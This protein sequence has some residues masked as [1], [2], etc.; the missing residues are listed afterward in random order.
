MSGYKWEN[1]RTNQILTAPAIWLKQKLICQ[2][3]W[4]TIFWSVLSP[5]WSDYILTIFWLHSDYILTT[6]WLNSDYIL[7][8]FWSHSDY[9]L[10]TSWLHSDCI[11]TSLWLFP[12]TFWLLAI[13]LALIR[14][15][16]QTVHFA[17]SRPYI[18]GKLWHLNPIS[19]KVGQTCPNSAQTCITLKNQWAEIL[20]IFVNS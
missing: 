11:L 3:S 18:F 5:F 17:S 2:L 15:P 20:I 19:P 1:G 4:L 8:T 13:F 12:T 6:F 9:I 10:T 16:G 7:T 14:S